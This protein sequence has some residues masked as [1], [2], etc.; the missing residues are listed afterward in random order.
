MHAYLALLFLLLSVV[1]VY[2]LGR[3]I[4]LNQC[5]IFT[6]LVNLVISQNAVLRRRLQ[7]IRHERL[8]GIQTFDELVLLVVAWLIRNSCGLIIGCAGLFLAHIAIILKF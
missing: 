5:A 6:T 4:I 1:R 3:N 7:R 8:I 2:C